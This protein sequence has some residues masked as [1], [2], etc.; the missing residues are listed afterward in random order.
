MSPHD[1]SRTGVRYTA[2][3][4]ALLLFDA[5]IVAGVASLLYWLLN[6]GL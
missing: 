2:G 4:I 5:A 6:R 1:P 3:V